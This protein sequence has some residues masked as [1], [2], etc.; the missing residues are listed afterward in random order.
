MLV[1][2]FREFNALSLFGEKFAPDACDRRR[3]DWL[4]VHC[5]HLQAPVHSKYGAFELHELDLCNTGK[6]LNFTTSFITPL[7]HTFREFYLGKW[8]ASNYI[9]A[10]FLLI[11]RKLVNVA[12]SFCCF[13]SHGYFKSY[14]Q[15]SHSPLWL[16]WVKFYHAY[17]ASS[18]NW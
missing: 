10:V 15:I 12:K 9:F 18:V 6:G 14:P 1:L 11:A 3:K 4:E 5:I 16:I 7:L 2:S 13:R 8:K 17:L